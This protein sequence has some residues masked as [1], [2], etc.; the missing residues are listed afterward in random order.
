MERWKK[1]PYYEGRYEAST[2]GRVRNSIT[3]ECITPYRI[4][5]DD[6][7]L[8]VNL[9]MNGKQN[10]IGLHRVIATTFVPNYGM[11]NVVHHKD[12][13][14]LNNRPDNLMWVSNSYNIALGKGRKGYTVHVYRHGSELLHTFRTKTDFVKSLG[15]QGDNKT[16]WNRV[17]PYLTKECDMTYGLSETTVNWIKSDSFKKFYEKYFNE[18]QMNNAIGNKNAKGKGKVQR[19][20]DSLSDNET[21]VVKKDAEDL[22]R[23]KFK[24]KYNM[25]KR[26]VVKALSELES[27][28]A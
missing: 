19:W 16:V 2:Y 20:L 15:I 18:V 11:K 22:S 1:V 13:N 27:Q 12:F 3:E 10:A 25:D 8:T 5:P 9:M 26:A 23:S 6:D 7:H 28:S 21:E 4:N 14:P 17:L 24:S